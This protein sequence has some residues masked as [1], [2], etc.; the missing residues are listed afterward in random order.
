MKK[1]I[2]Q[3]YKQISPETFRPYRIV[4]TVFTSDG[5]RSRLCIETYATENIALK[6]IE[7]KEKLQDA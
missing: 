1:S 5:P 6:A 3:L 2:F 7:I 4:E